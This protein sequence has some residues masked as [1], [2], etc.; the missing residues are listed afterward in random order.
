MDRATQSGDWREVRD[1]Y[2]TTFESFIEINAAFKVKTHTYSIFTGL[3]AF[4]WA[5]NFFF[6]HGTI[7]QREANGLFNTIEDS[8]VNAK[9]V[10]AVYDT[11]LG[12]VR[13]ACTHTSTI[14]N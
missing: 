14:G 9:F 4:L 11:L 8:G 2:L 5:P 1:F 7:L 10:N 12:T 6:F 13:D 3:P